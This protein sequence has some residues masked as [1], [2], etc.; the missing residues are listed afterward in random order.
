MDKKVRE[1]R[2]SVIRERGRRRAG[3]MVACTALVIVVALFFW[4]RSSDVFA[5]ERVTATK[6]AHVT[7]AQIASAT[8]SVRGENLLAL[9]VD[10]IVERLV[11][12]PY[13]RS[14]SVHRRFPNTLEVRV[15]EHSAAARVR[16]GD[17]AIWFVSADGTVLEVSDDG[18]LPLFVPVPETELQAG[19]VLPELIKKALPLA[20]LLRQAVA[21]GGLPAIDHVT[22]VA[23][24][25]I[26]LHLRDGS[27]VRMGEP[28]E[29]K[30]KLM[31]ATAMIQRYLRD[32]RALQ[33][34]DVSVPERVAVNAG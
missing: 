12:L 32:G 28:V 16:A 30:Q 20:A 4:L 11:A 25:E 26:V 18:D 13:V 17:G 24:G 22:I 33:Y 9:S 3:I 6:T 29:L 31:V 2:R 8:A 5:V 1:R 34:V 19:S 15:V 21:D 14:A 7:E 10:P 27:E 23:T